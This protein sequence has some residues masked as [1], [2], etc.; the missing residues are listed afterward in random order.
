MEK[1]KYSV[2]STFKSKNSGTFEIIERLEGK[3][4]K[5]KFQDGFITDTHNTSILR[6]NVFNPYYPR[7][8]GLGYLGEGGYTS[9]GKEYSIWKGMFSRCYGGGGNPKNNNYVNCYV[10]QD[11]H[12]FQKFGEWYNNQKN[13]H[14]GGFHLDKDLTV[15]GSK[16]YSKTT[17][18]II[19]VQVNIVFSKPQ[20][21]FSD[22]VGVDYVKKEGVFRS[23]YTDEK[24]VRHYLGRFNRVEDA[25]NAYVVKKREICN[26]VIDIHK[27]SLS[28]MV[29]ENLYTLIDIYYPIKL[30]K[31]NILV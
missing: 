6:G 1:S 18:S 20:I 5:I 23:S 26:K 10:E 8:E 15:L 13:C 16:V 7:V 12:N 19:P 24:G 30:Y 22:N 27:E 9:N 11:W 28:E 14:L 4:S 25:R 2:G 3:K 29:V 21:N 31:V 17:C